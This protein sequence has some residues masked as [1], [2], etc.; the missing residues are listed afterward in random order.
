MKYID[1]HYFFVGL[2]VILIQLKDTHNFD[3]NWIMKT[4]KRII[5]LLT[6]VIPTHFSFTLYRK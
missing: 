2:Y 1:V 4:V 5:Y 6:Q 3:M